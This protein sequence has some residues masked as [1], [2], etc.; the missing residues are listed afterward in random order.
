MSGTP[1]EAFTTFGELLKHLRRRSRL[2][3]QELGLAVGYSESY[4]TRLEGDARTPV[5][6]MVKSRFIDALNLKH[7][8]ELAKRLIEL[9]EA[10]R[11]QTSQPLATSRH[12]NLPV[13]LT[14]FIGRAHELVEVNRLLAANRLVTLTGSGGV[15]KTRLALEAASA[16]LEQFPDGVWLVELTSLTDAGL[17]PQVVARALGRPNP[18]ATAPTDA[19]CAYLA[20]KQALLV[21]DNCEHLIQAC[22]E[23][24][25]ILLRSCP[26]LHIL[27]T[28]REALNIPGRN[29][30]ACAAHG[31]R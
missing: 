16:L 21:V 5:P 3:Q 20:D 7:E 30:M 18:L 11:E 15:G 29:S 12:S 19:L 25:E 8:P 6:G 22:A 13:Q 4:I 23:L 1:T 31:S 26:Q 10:T 24:V 27:T 9:A 28:S 17:L 14:R 2:T